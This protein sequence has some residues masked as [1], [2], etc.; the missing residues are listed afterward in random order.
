MPAVL[1][2]SLNVGGFFVHYSFA[3]VILLFSEEGLCFLRFG[4]MY[5][6]S[7]DDNKGNAVKEILYLN[8]KERH[9]NVYL[10]FI[11]N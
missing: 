3:Q 6:L 8:V 10:Q 1:T 7:L 11:I 4:F 5:E 9:P 2:Y